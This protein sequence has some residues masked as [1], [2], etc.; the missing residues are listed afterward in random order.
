[1]ASKYRES[2]KRDYGLVKC[3]DG[4][5]ECMFCATFGVEQ[6]DKVPYQ[7]GQKRQR[8]KT[9][10][11][12][13]FTAPFATFN[14]VGHMRLMHPSKWETFQSLRSVAEKDDFFKVGVKHTDI[15]TKTLTSIK[16]RLTFLSINQSLT[17]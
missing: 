11:K 13:Y 15:I 16:M 6:V 7:A 9:E 12:K 10:K 4:S 8:V 17:F 2:Y 5:A 14:I 1:M 3:Q